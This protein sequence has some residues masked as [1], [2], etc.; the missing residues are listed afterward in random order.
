MVYIEIIFIAPQGLSTKDS[1]HP[2]PNPARLLNYLTS[3]QF[4]KT[5]MFDIQYSMFD[6]NPYPLMPRR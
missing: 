2:L 5:S 4:I 3:D 6:I 1:A